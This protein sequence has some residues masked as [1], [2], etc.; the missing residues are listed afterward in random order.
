MDKLL[1]TVHAAAV[2]MLT[3][4]RGFVFGATVGVAAVVFL[5]AT[6]ASS[7]L[8]EKLLEERNLDSSAE[9]ARNNVDTI[10]QSLRRGVSRSELEGLMGETRAAFATTVDDIDVYRARSVETRYGSS[11]LEVPDHARLAMSTGQAVTL[12]TSAHVLYAQPVSA[13]A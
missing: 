2:R 5:G 4:L 10:V 3:T 12:K 9:I 1:G 8:Y 7:L 13:E 11:E 6:L